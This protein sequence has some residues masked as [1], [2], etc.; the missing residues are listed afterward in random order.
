MANVCI[1]DLETLHSAEECGH[2]GLDEDAHEDWGTLGGSHRYIPIGWRNYAALG[3]SLGCALPVG[4]L[5][6]F[7]DGRSLP[8]FL[9]GMAQQHACLVTFNGTGFDLPLLGA[10]ATQLGVDHALMAAWEAL[11]HYD[12]LAEIWKLD[13]AQKYAKG[14]NSLNAL[15]RANGLGG[16]TGDGAQAPRDWQDGK[17]AQVINYCLH[18]CW[19]TMQLYQQIVRGDALQRGNGAPALT[20]PLPSWAGA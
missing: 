19:L 20:L 5:P 12:M 8:G 11:P 2:C 1:L 6:Q 16:K 4:G 10:L 7:F 15:A 9:A 18:D 13:G 14:T 17:H 3:L